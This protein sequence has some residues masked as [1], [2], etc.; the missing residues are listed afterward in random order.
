MIR[1]AANCGVDAVKLQ[2]RHNPSFYTKS[3]LESRYDSPHAFGRT[4]G[5]HRDALELTDHEFVVAKEFAEKNGVEFLCTAFDIKTADFL[6][7]VGISAFK[8]ASADL[9]N[10]PLLRHVATMARPILLSTGGASLQ[11]VLRAYAECSPRL[12]DIG[13]LQCTAAYPTLAK[14]LCLNVIKTYS[15]AFPQAVVGLSSHH[16]GIAMEL[17]AFGLG[18]RIVEKH[19]TLDRSW[20][21]TDH[22]FSLLPDELR[23]LVQQLREG[24]TALGSGDKVPLTSEAGLL[25][26]EGKKLVAARFIHRGAILGRDDIAAKAPNDG[27]PPYLI[28]SF[29][30]R[31]A[32]EDI[33][34]DQPLSWDIVS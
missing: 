2:K 15:S 25:Y 6:Y 23:T 28:D 29:I 3:F 21:G 17:V 4:Y 9:V 34:V 11:D 22:C 8:I 18:A 7:E 12:N 32:L 19:F 14:D 20:K 26:K 5:E 10:T 1:T 24:H 30:G 27:L 16:E 33:S 13:I 31:A